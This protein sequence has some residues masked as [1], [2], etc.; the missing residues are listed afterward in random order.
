MA[1]HR[2]F[3]A[4]MFT[5]RALLGALIGVP[6]TAKTVTAAPSVHVQGILQ[7][8]DSGNLE[9]Y[10]ALC[11][12]NACHAIDALGISVHPKNPLLADDLAAMASQ[13]VQVSIFPVR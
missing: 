9:G 8:M 7:P 10:Y 12:E 1:G 3:A 4:V 5:R 13:R 2:G 6:M 11:G